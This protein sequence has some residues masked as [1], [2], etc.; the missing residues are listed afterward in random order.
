MS[1]RRRLVLALVLVGP[2][3]AL[4]PA[5]ATRSSG[6]AAAKSPAER[7][8]PFAAAPDFQLQDSE[9]RVRTLSEL[10]GTK[11]LILVIYRGH[12]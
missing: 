4:A 3:A 11:G 10:V 5:C 1:S 6:G 7:P 9:G 12:W 2:L 8:P